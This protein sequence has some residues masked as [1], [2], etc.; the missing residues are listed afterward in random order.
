MKSD[1]GPIYTFGRVSARQKLSKLGP[2]SSLGTLLIFPEKGL[3]LISHVTAT[4]A[5][6]RCPPKAWNCSLPKTA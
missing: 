3:K 2:I 4:F 5:L 6:K 1:G